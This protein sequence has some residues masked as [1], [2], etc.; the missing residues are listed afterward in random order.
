MK[1]VGILYIC[2]G[3]YVVFW[4][5]F[6]RSFEKYFLKNSEIHYFVFTDSKELSHENENKRIHRI[7]QENLRWPGNTLFRFK[8]FVDNQNCFLDMDYLFFFNANAECKMVI[9]EESFLPQDK[10][11]LFVKHPGFYSEKPYMFPYEH[12]KKS[13][14]YLSYMGGEYYICGGIN[15][16]KRDSFLELSLSLMRDIDADYQNGIIAKWH[17]ESHINKYLTKLNPEEYSILSP[18]YCYP[19]GWTIPFEKKI[20]IRNKS[21]LINVNG[22]KKYHFIFLSNLKNG[23]LYHIK[24]IVLGCIYGR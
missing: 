8:I 14:A 23:F 17:D 20:L 7:Y 11:L 19:E 12:S 9:S 13:K 22:V 1:K 4:D 15:G 16:G 3:E 21:K 24:K 2:T 10:N 18:A 6:Y 5:G